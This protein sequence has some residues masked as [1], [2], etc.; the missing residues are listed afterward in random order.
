MK[1]THFVPL[2]CFTGHQN[3]LCLLWRK[4]SGFF[5]KT[6]DIFRNI[7]PI[8]FCAVKKR[9]GRRSP[10]FPDFLQTAALEDR[11]RGRK[12]FGISACQF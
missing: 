6:R 11:K 10:V 1:L 3:N 7:L 4:K 12:T 2:F 9:P 5:R 8:S